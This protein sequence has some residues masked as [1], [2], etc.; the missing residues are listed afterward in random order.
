VD[1][2]SLDRIRGIMIMWWKGHFVKGMCKNLGKHPIHE[3]FQPI[4]LGIGCDGWAASTPP[5]VG[6]SG[7][8]WGPRK[9]SHHWNVLWFTCKGYFKWMDMCQLFVG[10][11]VYVVNMGVYEGIHTWCI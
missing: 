6:I 3:T 8:R 9:G 4:W 7:L 11:Y 1:K 2:G 5:V 10:V